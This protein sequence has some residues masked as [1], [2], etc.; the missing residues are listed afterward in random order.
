MKTRLLRELTKAIG[1][2]DGVE[3]LI[4]DP[5]AGYW[6]AYFETELAALRVYH[7]YGGGDTFGTRRIQYMEDGP[8][9]GTY[10]LTTHKGH[11]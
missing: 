3:H 2:D 10:R 8:M 11:V 7:H 6:T 9:A 1:T 5:E 4:Y